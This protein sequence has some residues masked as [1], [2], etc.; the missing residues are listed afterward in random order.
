[1]KKRIADDEF[2]RSNQFL[3]QFIPVITPDRLCG[4]AVCAD[5]VINWDSNPR[6]FLNHPFTKRSVLLQQPEGKTMS[7][8][9]KYILRIAFIFSGNR[10]IN[11][12]NLLVTNEFSELMVKE[13]NRYEEKCIFNNEYELSRISNWFDVTVPEMRV[14]WGFYC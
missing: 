2:P 12:L 13:T 5:P 8:S 14:F 10:P 11:F 9:G 6:P 4:Q 7:L 1:M 3:V